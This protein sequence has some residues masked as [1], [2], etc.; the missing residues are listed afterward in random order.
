MT[1]TRQDLLAA[2]AT[3]VQDALSQ[4]GGFPQ[5]VDVETA[6]VGGLDAIGERP[7]DDDDRQYIEAMVSAFEVDVE[8]H[9]T[10]RHPPMARL[11]RNNH[12]Q[13]YWP[14]ND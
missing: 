10:G 12:H 7:L 2:L 6:V 4:T 14:G 8:P 3:A 13:W 1:I 11:V 9:N 5:D